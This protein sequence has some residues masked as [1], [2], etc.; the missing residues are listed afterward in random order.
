MARLIDLTSIPIKKKALQLAK[1]RP[2]SFTAVYHLHK[3]GKRTRVCSK[4]FVS[5]LGVGTKQI[6]NLN[7]AMWLAP[8]AS[9][10]EDGRG[11]HEM[12]AK[13]QEAT[14]KLIDRHILSFPRTI[15][16]YALDGKK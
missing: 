15:S 8:N 4:A 3:N 13:I 11:R 9:V 5:V 6:R 12:H 16:H 7:R 2:K 1:R 10:S 14:I